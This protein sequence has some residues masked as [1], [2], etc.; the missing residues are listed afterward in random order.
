[1]E[2]SFPNFTTKTPDRYN[3]KQAENFPVEIRGMPLSGKPKGT[4][5][6]ATVAQQEVNEMICCNVTHSHE[7]GYG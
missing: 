3:D 5:L 7:G 4:D 2:A 6:L 1:M